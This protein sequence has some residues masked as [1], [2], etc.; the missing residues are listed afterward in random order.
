MF[1]FESLEA[2]EKIR[3]YLLGHP[4]RLRRNFSSQ[5]QRYQ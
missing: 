5:Q 3:V 2:Q 1:T 4:E